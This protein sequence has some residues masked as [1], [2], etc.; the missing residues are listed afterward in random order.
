VLKFKNK[1]G[2]LRV[3]HL[4]VGKKVC[5]PYIKE[6]GVNFLQ[7]GSD[8]LLQVHICYKSLASHILLQGSRETEITRVLD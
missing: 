1:F 5:N 3:K 7:P 6:T 2:T 4:S 8:S